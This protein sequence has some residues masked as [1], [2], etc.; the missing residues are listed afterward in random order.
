[1]NVKCCRN[2]VARSQ[3][4]TCNSFPV[5]KILPKLRYIKIAKYAVYFSEKFLQFNISRYI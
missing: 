5:K 1:M 2:V 4:R 3:T